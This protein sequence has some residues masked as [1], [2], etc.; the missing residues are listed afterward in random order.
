MALVGLPFPALSAITAFP[1]FMFLVSG[2]R[3]DLC[4]RFDP[5]I[6]LLMRSV[7]STRQFLKA[8]NSAATFGAIFLAA[9]PGLKPSGLFSLTVSR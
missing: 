3:P 7:T 5:L 2:D 6:D 9:N 1:A 4:S 8:T